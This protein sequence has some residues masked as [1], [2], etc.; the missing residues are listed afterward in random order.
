M[1]PA[2]RFGKKINKFIANMQLA[3]RRRA[4][5]ASARPIDPVPWR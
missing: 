5:V 1:K 3:V 4:G 2:P